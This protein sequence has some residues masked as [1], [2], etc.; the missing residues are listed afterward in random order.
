MRCIQESGSIVPSDNGL[1]LLNI[2]LASQVRVKWTSNECVSP[3]GLECFDF[4]NRP[5]HT[6]LLSHGY[7]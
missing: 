5:F 1:S 6:A 7:T 3:A 2:T 4:N